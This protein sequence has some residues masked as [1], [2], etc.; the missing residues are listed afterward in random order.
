ML[1]ELIQIDKE[2]FLYLNSLGTPF[3]DGFWT[4]LSRTISF[5]TVPL[6]LLSLFYSYRVFGLKKTAIILGILILLI[7]CT[8]QL[9]IAFKH[10]IR[11]LRPCYDGEIKELMRMVKSY[12]GGKF[13]YFSAHA[14]N[15]AA[16]AFFWKTFH[17]I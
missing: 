17:E 11:R 9:S 16:F 8:E 1:E 7:T 6:Y 3:W 2:L 14:A 15:S 10:G 12:C 4:Y 13:S 5:I